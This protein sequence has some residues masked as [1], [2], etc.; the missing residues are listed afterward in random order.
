MSRRQVFRPVA[1]Y[2]RTTREQ[3]MQM[4]T[5]IAGLVG[6][7]ATIALGIALTVKAAWGPA[8]WD[9]FHLALSQHLGFALGH[10]SIGV[11]L[12]I[13]AVTLLLG[14]AWAVRWGTLVN[15]LVIGFAIELFMNVL[16]PDPTVTAV[17]LLYLAVGTFC[18]AFGSV[19]YTRAGLGAGARDSLILVLSQRLPFTVGQIRLGLEATVALTGWLLGGP[20][21]LATLVIVFSVGP[22]SDQLYKL[23][24][25]GQLPATVRI[26]E[27]A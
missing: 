21:G 8:S 1:A 24:G 9:I 6:G 26:P 4:L 10:V 11:S 27:R 16:V 20:V 3:G 19:V 7:S 25:R 22:L 17:R 18:F 14:G 2:E 12:C 13:V 15:T 23:M 5:R